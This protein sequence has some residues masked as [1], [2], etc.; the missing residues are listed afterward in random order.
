MNLL[1]FRWPYDRP[2]ITVFCVSAQESDPIESSI[3][4]PALSPFHLKEQP[5]NR[6][7]NGGS[8]RER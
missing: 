7:G 6:K 5:N 1:S 2:D 8:S 3:I 4:F